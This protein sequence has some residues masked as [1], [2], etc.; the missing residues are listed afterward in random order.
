MEHD[1]SEDRGEQG[2]ERAERAA[3]DDDLAESLAALS[4]LSSARLGL[5]DLLTQVATFAVQA[6]PGAEVRG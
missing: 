2:R 3:E 1:S 6:I 4:R 5:E